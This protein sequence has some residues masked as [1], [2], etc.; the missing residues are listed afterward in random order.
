MKIGVFEVRADEARC[1]ENLQQE[2]GFEAV[3][4][5]EPLTLENAELVRGC[6]G[7][8]ILGQSRMDEKLLEKLRELG[9]G[10]LT[11]RYECK[12]NNH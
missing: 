8:S 3:T 10:C 7:I 6:Q 11:T 9:V 5:Q 2:L 12:S 1:L 4:R